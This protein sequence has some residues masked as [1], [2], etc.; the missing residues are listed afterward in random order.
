MQKLTLLIGVLITIGVFN[1]CTY[2]KTSDIKCV[3]INNKERINDQD[4]SY[5]LIYTENGV[6]TLQDDLLRGNF[7]SSTWYG[8]IE[9][10]KS[11][12][13]RTGGFRIPIFSQ[14]QNIITKPKLC[15]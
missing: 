12:S 11:Y 2:L 9:K 4:Q 7:K 1:S 15:E 3:E 10:G 6:F 14:Y 8:K 5:Y 13:F